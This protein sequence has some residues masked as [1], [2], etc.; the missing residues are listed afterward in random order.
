[1]SS[2]PSSHRVRQQRLTAGRIVSAPA[3]FVGQDCQLAVLGVASRI[4]VLH[5]GSLV[6]FHSFVLEGSRSSQ[7]ACL[8]EEREWPVRTAS[9]CNTS[10]VSL[11]SAVSDR[12]EQL[13]APSSDLEASGSLLRADLSRRAPVM[14]LAAELADIAATARWSLRNASSCR[15]RPSELRHADACQPRAQRRWRPSSACAPARSWRSRA[16]RSSR[17]VR[18]RA[19]VCRARCRCGRRPERGGAR[20][21]RPRR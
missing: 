20:G 9:P 1:M 10:T 4:R 12:V 8:I 5:G 7:R 17:R 13:G 14:A 11:R 15:R 16:G 21:R 2:P 6:T 19:P 3:G 18:R